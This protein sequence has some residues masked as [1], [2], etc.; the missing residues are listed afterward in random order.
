[1]SVNIHKLNGASIP[2]CFT[3][4]TIPPKE[5]FYKGLALENW[6][7]QPKLGIVGSRKMSSYGRHATELLSSSL[8]S[9][10]VVIISG[11][12]YGVDAAAHRAALNAGGKTVAILPTS[13]H[14]IYPATHLNLANQITEHGAL[15][16]EYAPH[17]PIYKTNFTNRNRL[18]AALS[19]VLLITEAAVNSGSLH[20][21]RF[22]L[23]Q[24]KTVM[25]VPGNINN[26]GS[27]GCNNLIKSGALPATTP[28]DIFAALGLNY[29]HHKLRKFSGS[30]AEQAVFDLISKG[31][32]DQEEIAARLGIEAPA[33]AG[34][35]T[36]L[37]I[38][39]YI[40][41]LGAGQWTI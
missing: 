40:R 20:T 15:I 34:I 39:G 29:A 12:A 32:S 8:A 13:L 6:I 14:S 22:A 35:L 5:L 18:V 23:E 24:G 1:M 41:R 26:P 31:L 30:K 21:A 9:A 3:H 37:E 36:G 7:N 19:D 4:L 16:S 38:N 28:E 2:A 11:L 10:G 25:A 33:M 27:E 17:S